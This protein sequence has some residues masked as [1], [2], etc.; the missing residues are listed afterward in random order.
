MNHLLYL[1][2]R[3]DGKF[4]RVG[5]TKHSPCL[6]LQYRVYLL[7]TKPCLA[8]KLH[9]FVVSPAKIA[10]SM[11]CELRVAKLPQN[12]KQ[13]EL[14]KLSNNTVPLTGWDI[15]RPSLQ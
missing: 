9:V 1:I 11:P 8:A 3:C 14:H 10:F 13:Q 6:T 12:G 4:G 5:G 2:F 15:T 7:N